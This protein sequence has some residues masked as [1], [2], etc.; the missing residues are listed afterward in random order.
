MESVDL[1]KLSGMSAASI[2][3]VLLVYRI[4]KSVKGKKFVSKC[5]GKKM[6]VGF[7]VQDM[8]EETPK[9]EIK[10]PIQSCPKENVALSIENVHH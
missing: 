7:D 2:A 9:L 8:S 1:A 10:N 3:I 4:L 6:D 5:C